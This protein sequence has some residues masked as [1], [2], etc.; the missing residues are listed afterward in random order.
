M[1]AGFVTR[2]S[3]GR[4]E[5]PTGVRRDVESGKPRF[6]LVCPLGV[7]FD[8]LM[9]T[10]WAALMGRG[11]EKYGDRNWE[12]A[13][14]AEE[15]E[16]FRSSAFR[17]FMQWMC[18]A[19]DEDHAAAVLFNIQGA[20]YVRDRIAGKRAATLTD[21]APT[22]AGRKRVYLAGPISKGDLRTNLNQA[23]AAFVAIARA[24]LAPFCPHWSAYS[25]PC[26][27][28]GETP[29]R[30]YCYA[31]VHGNDDMT[32]ADWMAVDLPWVAVADAVLRLPG[33]SAGA[34]RET[35]EATER[36]IPVFHSVEDVIAW[37]G[38]ER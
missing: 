20:E 6:D 18:G 22:P 16:R 26:Y 34:D 4:V 15:F 19:R 11:A 3:G 31:T 5:F 25:K 32:H 30:V 14:T 8:D 37:A 12:K 28:T 21:A 36:G 33:K 10:R 27:Q 2:D 7:A 17:H 38:A 29:N 13:E 1:G 9:L 23:T 35:A 24:G